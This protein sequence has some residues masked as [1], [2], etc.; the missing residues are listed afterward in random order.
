M[1]SLFRMKR[2]A[3]AHGLVLACA[4]AGTAASA[5]TPP[6]KTLRL[7]PHADVKVLDPTFTIAY[8]TRN[9]GYMVYDTL[10]GFDAKGVPQPQMVE[11]YTKS[12]DARTW[13]FT[14]RPG[15]KF[16][17]GSLVTSADAVASMQRWASRDN[18]G[19]AMTAAGGEWKAV[20]A[21]TFTLTLKQPF[22]LVLDG[23]AKAS[24][25][26]AFILPERLAKMP[27]NAPIQEVLGSG[28]FVFKR[29]EWVPGS[30][31]VFTKSP[32][33]VGRSEAPSGFAGNKT[34]HMDRVEWLILPDANSASAALKAGEVDVLEEVPP[35]N[36]AP[37]LTDPAIKIVKRGSSQAYMALN[38]AQP[39]FNNPAMRQAV[40]MA[41]NQERFTAAMGYPA[42]L[43]VPYCA[44]F[45][46]C[47]SAND[48]AAGS[49]R[50]QPRDL[51]KARQMVKDAGYKGEKVVVMV[52]TDIAYLNGAALIAAQTLKSIGLNV[53]AQSMDWSS[54]ISRRTKKDPVEQGGWSVY[55]TSAGEFDLNSPI[56]S[57][58]LGAACGNSLPG[59]PCDEQLDKLRTDWIQQTEP[60]ARRTA[61]EAFQ[62]RAYETLPYVPVGQFSPAYGVRASLKHTELL[63][64]TPN[65]WVLDK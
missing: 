65:V 59:W 38:Q 33:Y 50:Y 29:D 46:I 30:K 13:T 64:S 36:I 3:L 40:M 28:P 23:M 22:G 15:L 1:T 12:T 4:L 49:E 31:V 44:T 17:D 18:T 52:P 35:D 10:F 8:I 24:S 9:F 41:V 5:Q 56:N 37:L 62:R 42:N 25:Y 54:V 19:K 6:V 60:A 34:A 2:V 43:R 16:S 48:T 20:D 26:T 45:F 63:W 32:T 53:D 21:R 27:T 58:N 47:G 55:V 39:P 61:L 57:T 51:A 7:V 11:K 14:L